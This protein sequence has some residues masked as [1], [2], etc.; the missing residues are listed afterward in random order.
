MF[1][2]IDSETIK[3][4]GE[5]QGSVYISHSSCLY[6]KWEG[7]EEIWRTD[8][9]QGNADKQERQYGFSDNYRQSYFRWPDR[10]TEEEVPMKMFCWLWGELH[11]ALGIVSEGRSS[12]SRVVWHKNFISKVLLHLCPCAGLAEPCQDGIPARPCPCARGTWSTHCRGCSCLPWSQS[13]VRDTMQIQ[14]RQTRP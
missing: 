12:T 14:E 9:V 11:W 3:E 6:F 2:N 10:L 7:C 13:K 8:V 1:Q 4:R 5:C